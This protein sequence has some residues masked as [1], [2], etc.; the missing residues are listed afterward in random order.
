M[1]IGGGHSKT[2]FKQLLLSIEL[3]EVKE[4]KE[5]GKSVTY[6]VGNGKGK[7]FKIS[8]GIAEQHQGSSEIIT[9][10]YN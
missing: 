3:I 7:C 1:D 9:Q 6:I 2:C 5:G 8:E 4:H 10:I